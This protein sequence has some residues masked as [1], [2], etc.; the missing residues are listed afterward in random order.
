ML[1]A[2]ASARGSAPFGLLRR[3]LTAL[4]SVESWRCRDEGRPLPSLRSVSTCACGARRT[5]GGR[6]LGRVRFADGLSR[7]RPLFAEVARDDFVVIGIVHNADAVH[8]GGR[9]KQS[10]G[11]TALFFRFGFHVA[12]RQRRLQ[13]ARNPFGVA[14]DNA[15]IGLR[16]LVGFAPALLPIAQRANRNVIAQRE[17]FLRHAQRAANDADLRAALHAFQIGVGTRLR[18]GVRKRGR[19]DLFFCHG[20]QWPLLH[21]LFR[22]VGANPHELAVTLSNFGDSSRHVPFS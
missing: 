7:H 14:R 2:S 4:L 16:G 11:Q 17:F 9:F 3:G 6:I 20:P 19:H 8:V 21:G 18:V 15:K 22:A 10:F 5:K 12:S 1:D 13:Q